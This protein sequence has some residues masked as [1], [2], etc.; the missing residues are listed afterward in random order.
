MRKLISV[1][2]FLLLA[3]C[4]THLQVVQLPQKTDSVMLFK[5]DQLAGKQAGQ[6]SLLSVQTGTKQWRWVQV[7]AL[8]SP[9]ARINLSV[10]GWHNDGFIMPNPQ[11]QW[12]FSAI[13]TAISPKSPF[14]FSRVVHS[15]GGLEYFTKNRWCWTTKP[16][17]NG[18]LIRLAD[19]SLWQV[20]PL[21]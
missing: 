9:L 10:E 6:Q 18:W 14:A 1:A 20:T 17:A 21:S 13:T 11:A 4:A 5:V 16:T 15:V 3:S 12:L 7:D 8:G 2:L 19:Q